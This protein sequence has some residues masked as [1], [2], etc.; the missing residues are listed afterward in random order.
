[1]PVHMWC[2]WVFCIVGKDYVRSFWENI[3][4]FNIIIIIIIII[5]L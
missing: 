5:I 3:L 4:Y 1:M 2:N